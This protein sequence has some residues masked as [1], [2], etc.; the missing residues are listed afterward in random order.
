VTTLTIRYSTV[1]YNCLK[2]GIVE[3]EVTSILEQRF[4]N[5]VPATMIAI[6]ESLPR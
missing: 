1:R 3:P 6:N 4:G 5:H 2:V